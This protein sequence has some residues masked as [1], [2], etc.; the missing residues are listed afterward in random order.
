[1]PSERNVNIIYSCPAFDLPLRGWKEN[2]I[3]PYFEVQCVCNVYYNIFQTAKWFA[4]KITR[5]IKHL[6]LSGMGL[7]MDTVRPMIVNNSS[8]EA[9]SVNLSNKL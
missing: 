9:Q 2:T 6:S 5:I 8:Q 4:M 3:N 1:M 7:Y